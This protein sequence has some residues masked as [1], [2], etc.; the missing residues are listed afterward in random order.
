MCANSCAT[1]CALAAVY[2]LTDLCRP[3]TPADEVLLRAAFDLLREF[4]SAYADGTGVAK[5]EVRDARH[6]KGRVSGKQG[7][8]ALQLDWLL[9]ETAARSAR[10]Q[11]PAR[12]SRRPLPRCGA[13][14]GAW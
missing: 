12:A 14:N 8:F 3:S 2:W 13:R 5:D 6:G 10:A 9:P 1:D 4:V 7:R 11:H